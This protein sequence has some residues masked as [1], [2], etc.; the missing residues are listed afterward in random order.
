MCWSVAGDDQASSCGSLSVCKLSSLCLPPCKHRWITAAASFSLCP[1][2]SFPGSEE[3]P[4][5]NLLVC[6][7]RKGSV[8]LYSLQQDISQK[9]LVSIIREC[10]SGGWKGFLLVF[11]HVL[12][13]KWCITMG[14]FRTSLWQTSWECF[15]AT[16]FTATYQFTAQNVYSHL[17]NNAHENNLS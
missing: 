8:H 7:D 10:L 13:V 14:R 4:F 9:M 3:K 5:G 15:H 1:P 6:G 17:L 2:A 16:D 11:C 12:E